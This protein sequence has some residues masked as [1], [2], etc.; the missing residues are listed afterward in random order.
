LIGVRAGI[1]LLRAGVLLAG[2][3]APGAAGS[4]DIMGTVTVTA[5][6]SRLT[7]W[8]PFDGEEQ[9]PYATRM[10]A[11]VMTIYTIDAFSGTPGESLGTPR[12]SLSLTIAGGT[13][14]AGDLT[15]FSGPN[16]AVFGAGEGIGMLSFGRV[17]VEG[18]TL[19]FEF[20]AQGQELDRTDFDAAEGGS[21]ITLSGDVR[22]TFQD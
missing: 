18:A 12:L 1:G 9:E 5:D 11:G 3:A 21:R 16:A 8:V 4:F 2:L 15:Y 6:D 20:V 22:V 13:V 17:T 19:S 7:L 14:R 10:A